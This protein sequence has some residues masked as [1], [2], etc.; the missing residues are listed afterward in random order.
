VDREP[1]DTAGAAAAERAALV[2]RNL[3]LL[4]RTRDKA[5]RGLRP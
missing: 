4:A 5:Y 1:S 3:K 2:E